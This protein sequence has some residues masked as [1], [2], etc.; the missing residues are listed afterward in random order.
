MNYAD[1]SKLIDHSLLQPNLTTA[2][3]D[4]GCK[5]ALMLPSLITAHARRDLVV[6]F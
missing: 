3:L 1:I 2:D 4:A 5:L 6:G